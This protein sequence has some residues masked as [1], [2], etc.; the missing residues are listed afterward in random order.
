MPL[1]WVIDR[2]PARL[3]VRGRSAGGRCRCQRRLD[4]WTTS[5]SRVGP[6]QPGSRR[7]WGY[8]P[9]RSADEHEFGIYTLTEAARYARVAPS[10][11]RHW[12]IRRSTEPPSPLL[13]FDQLVSLLVVG[14]LRRLAGVP[15]GRILAAEEDLRRRTGHKFPFA[16]EQ[17][18]VEGRQIFVSTGAQAEWVVTPL[19]DIFLVPARRGQLTVPGLAEP[20]VL[21]LPAWA[22]QLR[23]TFQYAN[24]RVVAWRPTHHVVAMPTVQLGAPCLDG[25]RIPTNVL[26]LAS[27]AGDSVDVLSD[28]YG[29]PADLVQEALEWERSLAA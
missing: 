29:L 12:L 15:L 2:Q 6:S 18:W 16:R 4:R 25:T 9:V 26:Y 10:T 8:D 5:R 1:C 13:S 22:E 7:L 17:L 23:G 14:A 27:Q 3:R 20:E 21:A 28:A 19:V 11:A 24:E